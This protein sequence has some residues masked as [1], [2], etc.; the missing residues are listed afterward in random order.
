MKALEIKEGKPAVEF[1]TISELAK[2]CGKRSGP[3]FRKYTALGILPEANFRTAPNKI[4]EREV[5][6]E[7]L[8]SKDILAPRLQKI[9]KG[10]KQ[11]IKIT[12]EQQHEIN[13]AFAYERDYFE[14]Y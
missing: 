1:M 5:A 14:N 8:Y 4:G 13:Q 2:F 7:R 11:G 6:G 9:F 12:P 10:V 3:S